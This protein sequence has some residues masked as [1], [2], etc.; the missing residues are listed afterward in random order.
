MLKHYQAARTAMSGQDYVAAVQLYSRLLDIS[1]LPDIFRARVFEYR[2]EC[3]WLLSEFDQAEQDYQAALTTSNDADQVARARVRLGELA[4]FRGDYDRSELIYQQALR[5]GTAVHNILV[6]GRARRGLGIL[7][8]RQGN[9]ERALNHLTQALVAFRQAGEAREQARVLTSLGRTYHARGEYQRAL[10]AHQE[11]LVIF[12]SLNDRWRI[13]QTLTDIGECHQSLYD[14]PNALHYHEQALQLAETVGAELL[15]PEIKRNL[16]VDLIEYGRYEEGLQYLE[17]AL[18]GAREL[19]NHEQEALTL[20][21]LARAYLQRNNVPLA[22]QLVA[23]LSAVAEGLNADR[24]R[25][26]AAMVRGELFFLLGEQAAAVT[27]LNTAMLAAQTTMDRGGL[28]KLHAVIG[29]I[30]DDPAIAAIHLE[31]AAEFIRQTADPLQDPQL[32]A[33][34]VYAPPV[35]AVLQAAGINPDKL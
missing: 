27:E 5:E 9:T 8:R 7:S 13:I 10:S 30:I 23:D 20:Y 15:K 26:L 32:K 34:F 4:D 22:D 3:H 33:C 1:T 28:W 19:H 24:Y 11:A 16:G 18:M 12:E 31:I 17:A 29:H 6:I 21:H 14:V 35:L 25:A 2:G